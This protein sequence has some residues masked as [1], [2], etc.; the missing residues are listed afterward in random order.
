MTLLERDE[1]IGTIEAALEG[2]AHEHGAML[3]LHGAPGIGKTSLLEFGLRAA[4]DAGFKVGTAAGSPMEAELPFGL[5]GQAIVALGGSDV[6]DVVDLARLGGQPA[7]FFRTF[8]W[9]D[10]QARE[11]PLVLALDDLHWGDRD[12]LELIAF[13]ARRLAGTRILVLGSLRPEPD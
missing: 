2:V 6:E 12:S 11:T 9:L 3:L 10:Q 4:R 1:A 5:L 13:L 7:R 8:R